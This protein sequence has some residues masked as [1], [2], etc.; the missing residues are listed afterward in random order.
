MMTPPMV[1][2]PAL[3]RCVD[4]ASSWIRCPSERRIRNRIHRGVTNSETMNATPPDSIRLSTRASSQELPG[5]DSVVERYD[6]F[7]YRLGGL[8]AL[9]GHDDDV[10][11]AS[12]VER[13]PYRA[14]P[15]G[16]THD[17]GAGR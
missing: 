17:L 1:G 15:V 14:S 10:A 8:V 12:L 6:V 5:H 3:T 4:G 13:E 7:T 16:V 11:R 2:V 9:T